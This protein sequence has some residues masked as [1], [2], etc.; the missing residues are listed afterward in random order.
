MLETYRSIIHQIL[1]DQRIESRVEM[2]AEDGGGDIESTTYFS[3]R[4]AVHELSKV[5]R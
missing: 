5:V 2:T 1:D 3:L 4:D